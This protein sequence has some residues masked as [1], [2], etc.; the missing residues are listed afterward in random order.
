MY[1]HGNSGRQRVKN[2]CNLMR[3]KYDW[4]IDCCCC[5]LIISCKQQLLWLTKASKI[6]SERKAV[7][8]V[9]SV[10]VAFAVCWVPYFSVF[11]IKPFISTPVD[12]SVD[13][14]TLWLGYANS[15]VNPF[16]Y[17]FYSSSFRDGFRRVLCRSSPCHAADR[18]DAIDRATGRSRAERESRTR[19]LMEKSGLD[20][21]A[22]T[23]IW[24]GGE[25]SSYVGR[26]RFI[27][28]HRLDSHSDISIH[29]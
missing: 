21:P 24:P 28:N 3:Q 16:L 8:T 22:T 2:K 5:L 29:V 17:A 13:L 11:V 23:T 1:T 19:C 4:L 10:V 14:L 26:E 6:V 27:I 12:Q 7:V 18:P 15:S 20:Y 9:A 25:T